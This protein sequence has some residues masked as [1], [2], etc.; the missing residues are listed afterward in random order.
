MID[1]KVTT[2][3]IDYTRTCKGLYPKLQKKLEE[4]DSPNL[5]L[6]L[7]RKLDSRG[8]EVMLE[9]LQF[10]EEQQ[11]TELLLFLLQKFKSQWQKKVVEALAKHPIGKNIR[12]EDVILKREGKQ[13]SLLLWNTE[14]NYQGLLRSGLLEKD[15]QNPLK[16]VAGLG[17]QFVPTALIEKTVLTALQS[18]MVN[19]KIVTMIEQT[20]K[21]R[22]IYLK[23]GG[24]T[25]QASGKTKP[26]ASAESEKLS[27]ELE[28][29]LL[30]AV[31]QYLEAGRA[32]EEK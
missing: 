15:A 23:L 19:A 2:L 7:L 25:I 27:E 1:M 30:D 26:K 32:K 21:D 12:F 29:A 3:A 11:K 17:I 16:Q 6:R 10:L 22:G 20:L 13:L 5:G 4:M 9:L 31:V 18:E 24:A 28:E 14:V 8:E